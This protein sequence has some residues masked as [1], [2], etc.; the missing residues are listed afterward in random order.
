[1]GDIIVESKSIMVGYWHMEDVTEEAI[2]DGWLHTGDM[3][4]YDEHGFIFIVDR[5]KT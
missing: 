5:K 2:V 1:M 4:Y 3:G